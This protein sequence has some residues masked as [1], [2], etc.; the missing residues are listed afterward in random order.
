MHLL[1]LCHHLDEDEIMR[2]MD[3]KNLMAKNEKFASE[4]SA[5][6]K[7]IDIKNFYAI[8]NQTYQLQSFS[9]VHA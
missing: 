2:I 7:N 1:D 9:D 8:Q 3:V 6:A 4:Y 5:A